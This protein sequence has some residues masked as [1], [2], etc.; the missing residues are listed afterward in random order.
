MSMTKTERSR[1]L[2]TLPCGVKVFEPAPRLP[3]PGEE[4]L[5]DTCADVGSG[6]MRK[7]GVI[8][9]SGRC[10][11]GDRGSGCKH[12]RKLVVAM[13]GEVEDLATKRTGKGDAGLRV[14]VAKSSTLPRNSQ[15][16][17]RHSQLLT[18]VLHE[19]TT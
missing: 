19:R 7:H 4:V 17:T 9:Y 12:L 6:G 14:S 2:C 5:S 1:L 13:W 16:A 10:A 15:L 3:A 8:L 11:D 18:E